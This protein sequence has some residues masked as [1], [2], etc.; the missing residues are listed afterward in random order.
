[1]PDQIINAGNQA[2]QK[3]LEDSIRS[4]SFWDKY[5]IRQSIGSRSDSDETLEEFGVDPSSESQ[6]DMAYRAA[7]PH[8]LLKWA[9]RAMYATLCLGLSGVIS[10]AVYT[11]RESPEQIA[12]REIES[13]ATGRLITA[14][15][16][17]CDFNMSTSEFEAIYE[18][19]TGQSFP[20]SMRDLPLVLMVSS[21][22]EDNV[23]GAP[24][25]IYRR[26]EGGVWME[27]P[28]HYIYMSSDTATHLAEDAPDH[29][30]VPVPDFE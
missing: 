9:G 25:I 23:I 16:T 11:N 7:A 29:C 18:R 4:A 13:I 30:Y 15:D 28:H 8:P 20:H 26:L 3:D 22:K 14:A 12:Q 19:R 10:F 6:R 21:T 17:N 2:K 24:T 27:G 5:I 1:M